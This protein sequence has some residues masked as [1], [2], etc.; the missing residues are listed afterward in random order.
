MNIPEIV[1]LNVLIKFQQNGIGNKL[2]DVAEML[3][4]EKCDSVSLAVGLHS[5]YGAAQRVY[6]KRGF[7][8]DGSG[9]WYKGE[10]LE[11]YSKCENDDDLTLYLLKRF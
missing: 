6:V 11:Q 3:S 8:P 4:K 7:I 1:D 5:G 9:V 10:Q 2:M